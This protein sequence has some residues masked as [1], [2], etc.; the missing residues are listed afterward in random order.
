MYCSLSSR[1]GNT[2][3]CQHTMTC[4]IDHLTALRPLSQTS[5]GELRCSP[6]MHDATR[7]LPLSSTVRLRSA[8]ALTS[9]VTVHSLITVMI[10]DYMSAQ[11]NGPFI[12]HAFP[13]PLSLHR[14]HR[15]SCRWCTLTAAA[16][17]ERSKRHP[18][19]R[20]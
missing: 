9:P 17:I 8:A 4:E 11:H 14:P 1:C 12:L 5:S 16:V 7:Q 18:C 10:T 6:M 3:R 13:T 2:C 19:G 20:L 15:R